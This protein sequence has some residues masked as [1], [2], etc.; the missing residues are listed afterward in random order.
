MNTVRVLVV[1]DDPFARNWIAMLL[2]RDWRTALV[3][4]I[5][6]PEE[7]SKLL[8]NSR[9]RIDLI[10]LDT[11]IPGDRGWLKRVV[12]LLVE[13]PHAPLVVAMATHTDRTVIQQVGATKLRGYLLKQ[14]INNSIAWAA[15]LAAQG[16]WVMTP[17]V[18]KM[19][20]RFPRRG[21]IL[22][23][24]TAFRDL[25]PH[26]TNVA[27]LAL[28]FSMERREMAHE[29]HITPD[30]GYGL[31]S[32]IYSS[33]GM[34]ELLDRK[35]DPR[36][37]FEGEKTIVRQLDEILNELEQSE[38]RSRSG[39]RRKVRDLESLAFHVLTMPDITSV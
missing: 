21:V 22:E 25:T 17:S 35:V 28:L 16:K 33:I 19:L 9:G 3:G 26:Q 34:D 12:D 20:D 15:A 8:E 4:D 32:A 36:A 14:E 39:K 27:R 23:G 5:A 11:E 6:E 1:E 38:K 29:L 10:L 37:F 24:R 2:A 13:H 31:V 7:L 30:H 18:E